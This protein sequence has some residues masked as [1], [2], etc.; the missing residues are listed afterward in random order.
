MAAI[1]GSHKCVMCGQMIT[2]PGVMETIDGI[3]M[4]FHSKSCAATFKKLKSIYGK[5]FLGELGNDNP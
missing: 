3:P 2:S 1:E 4:T 5:D